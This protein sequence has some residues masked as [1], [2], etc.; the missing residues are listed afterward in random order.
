MS[1][2]MP[3]MNPN[4]YPA[5]EEFDRFLASIP[6][7]K[8]S[9]SS[10][11]QA[12]LAFTAWGLYQQGLP[13]RDRP[14]CLFYFYDFLP[15]HGGADLGEHADA[16]YEASMSSVGNPDIGKYLPL[17]DRERLYEVCQRRGTL[18]LIALSLPQFVLDDA[19]FPQWNSIR[20]AAEEFLKSELATPIL[21]LESYMFGTQHYSYKTKRPDARLYEI[22][23]RCW[24]FQRIY[25][26][27][28]WPVRSSMTKGI[29][30]S[31]R[32]NNV[33]LAMQRSS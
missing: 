1:T 7:D 14:A 29:F 32:E 25:A 3:K 6:K 9:L 5:K 4:L 21:F 33:N 2:P 13:H 10:S 23:I 17:L 20:Q 18:K 16:L 31:I 28:A 8:P 19:L 15:L 24:T 11:D 12:N 26:R 22:A 27:S 30:V